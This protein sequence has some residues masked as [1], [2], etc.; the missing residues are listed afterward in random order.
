MKEMKSDTYK[1]KRF[2]PLK[3]YLISFNYD[4]LIRV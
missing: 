1:K 3:N 2:V 4:H